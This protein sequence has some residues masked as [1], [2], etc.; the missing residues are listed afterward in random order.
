[1]KIGYSKIDI[2][3][4]FSVELSGYG[5]YRKRKS[6]GI[7][8][9]VFSKSIYLSDNFSNEILI[10]SCDLIGINREVILKIRESI[11]RQTDIP[12]DNITISSTH[13]H[14]GPATLYLEGLGKISRKYMKILEE[15]III[16]GVKA[17]E[18]CSEGK[19]GFTTTEVDISYNREVENGPTD[20]KLKIMGLKNEKV[21]IIVY[22]YSCHCI[23]LGTENYLISADWP[24]Y[25]NKKLEEIGSE[26]VFLQGFCG[27]INIKEGWQKDF[28]KAE[29]YGGIL[30]EEI[31]K[32]IKEIELKDMEIKVKSKIIN[33]PLKIPDKEDIEKFYKEWKEKGTQWLNWYKF[34]DKWRKINLA[35]I[36]KNC[37]DFLPTEIKVISFGKEA[38]FFI[39][40]G[41]I[42]NEFSFEIKKFSPFKYNFFIGY[43]NDYVGYIPTKN[44]FFEGRFYASKVAP[45]FTNFFPFKENVGDFLIEGF[46]DLIGS[47]KK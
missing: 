35:K 32:K 5:F 42:F 6:K 19:I 38:C 15:K 24:Y 17:K 41:E 2:T 18:E 47:F 8:D 25:S 28:Y 27:D 16:S 26:G 14:S 3:P 39:A 29:Y 10:I 36:G 44:D 30:G 45:M 1:M 11:N 4:D 7:H 21:F 22:N 20:K 23:S 46:K 40:G 33:L 37:R 43:S 9:P 31:I 34:I 13:T 12:F